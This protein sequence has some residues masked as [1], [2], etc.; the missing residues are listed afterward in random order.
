MT[1]EATAAAYDKLSFAKQRKDSPHS[2]RNQ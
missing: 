1:N 2:G